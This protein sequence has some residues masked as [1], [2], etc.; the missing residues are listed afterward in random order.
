MP[1]AIVL[2][3]DNIEAQIKRLKPEVIEKWEKLKR[4][5]HKHITPKYLPEDLIYIGIRDL[6]EQEW[7]TIK[8]RNI[9]FY[10]PDDIRALG[11]ETVAAQTAEYF[12]NYDAVYITFDVDSLDPSIS[13]GTGTP[14][15]DGLSIEQAKVLIKT[16]SRM[17][18]FKALE[19]TEVNPLLDTEN[20]M[21]TAVVKILRD[22]LTFEAIS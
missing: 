14:V 18:N 4:T 2:G 7:N 9:R 10:N 19:V 22:S 21:A 17:P 13:R 12:S 1:V 8:T 11:I 15:P 16:F 6:E 20:R 3:I 5:G